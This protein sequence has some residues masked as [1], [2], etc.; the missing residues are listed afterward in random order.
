MRRMHVHTKDFCPV[1]LQGLQL[2]VPG[3]CQVIMTYDLM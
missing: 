1:G 2:V 3:L